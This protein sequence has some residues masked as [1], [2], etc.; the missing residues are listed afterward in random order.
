[1]ELVKELWLEAIDSNQVLE[2][3]N[4]AGPKIGLTFLMEKRLRGLVPLHL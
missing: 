2:Y 4:G 1:M 3:W